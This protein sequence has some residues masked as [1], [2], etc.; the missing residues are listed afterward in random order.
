MPE[1][2]LIEMSVGDGFDTEMLPFDGQ[3]L[4]SIPTGR[5]FQERPGAQD[6]V[7]NNSQVKMRPAGFMLMDYES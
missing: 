3:P 7:I 4:F 1:S 6:P 2:L 5:F